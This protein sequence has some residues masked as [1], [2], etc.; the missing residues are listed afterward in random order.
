M[1]RVVLESVKQLQNDLC[2]LQL[3]GKCTLKY[4]KVLQNISRKI[5]SGKSYYYLTF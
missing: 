4:Q 5:I 3:L 1:L 2:T